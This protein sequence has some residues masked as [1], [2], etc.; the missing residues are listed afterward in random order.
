MSCKLVQL[1]E[2]SSAIICGQ[3]DHECN[4]ESGVLLLSPN[5]SEWEAEDT[6]ENKKKY[7]GH[8]VGWSVAC[9]ICGRSLISKHNNNF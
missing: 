8:I 6:P 5:C 4:E 2:T 3:E 1:S 7:E 9:S